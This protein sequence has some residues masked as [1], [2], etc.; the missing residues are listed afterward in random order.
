MDA[1]RVHHF[2]WELELLKHRRQPVD[3]WAAGAVSGLLIFLLR[4]RGTG[5]E[6]LPVT[7]TDLSYVL[8]AMGSDFVGVVL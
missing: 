6:Y 5:K 4:N 7:A 2:V 1:L 8:S 3:S